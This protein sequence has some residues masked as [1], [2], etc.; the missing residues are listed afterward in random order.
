MYNAFWRHGLFVRGQS[1][2]VKAFHSSRNCCQVIGEGAGKDF[3]GPSVKALPL[4]PRFSFSSARFFL[5]LLLPSACYAG[6]RVDEA[7]SWTQRFLTRK[8]RIKNR[9]LFMTN[10]FKR[11]CLQKFYVSSKQEKE[12]YGKTTSYLEQRSRH[13]CQQLHAKNDTTN[14]FGY[15]LGE[16]TEN[17]KALLFFSGK[18][19]VQTFSG[20]I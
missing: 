10:K 11:K 20:S 9:S 1:F 3:R 13:F 7:V 17:N 4:P 5:C 8:F 18:E 16:S 15:K 2:S 14:L 19:T 6:Y 12:W